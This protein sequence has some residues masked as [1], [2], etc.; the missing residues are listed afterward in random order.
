MEALMEDEGFSHVVY[1]KE[2]D[3]ECASHRFKWTEIE[4]LT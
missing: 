2:A 4:P 1:S 3:L